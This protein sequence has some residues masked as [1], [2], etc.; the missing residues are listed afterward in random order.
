MNLNLS[1]DTC[2]CYTGGRPLQPG[3][4][5]DEVEVETVGVRLP[6]VL[7][8]VQDDQAGG[9]VDQQRKARLVG[10][11]GECDGQLWISMDYVAGTDAAQLLRE[12]YPAG[13]PP[14]VSSRSAAAQESKANW[15]LERSSRSMTGG[16][17]SGS[18]AVYADC[19]EAA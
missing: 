15:R 2:Y 11:R 1:D 16:S 8:A 14:E 6:A 10:Q 4:K 9:Q 17:S 13:M 12:H 19:C 3:R 18:G 7:S 5:L